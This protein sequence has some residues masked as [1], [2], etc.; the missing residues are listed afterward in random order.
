MPRIDADAHVIENERTW[1]YMEGS[2]AQYKPITVVP[3]DDR[4]SSRSY[5]LIDGTLIPRGG[6][7]GEEMSRES[8]EM[9]DIQARLRHM[10]ELEV[11]I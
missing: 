1:E 3:R 8:R 7:E 11:D 9:A 4:D 2:D 10:D 5:W 6:N